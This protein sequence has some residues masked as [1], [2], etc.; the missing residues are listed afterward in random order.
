VYSIT[1][2]DDGSVAYSGRAFVKAVGEQRSRLTK[3]NLAE[4]E[5]AFEEAGFFSL[6]DRYS[7]GMLEGYT[8]V[9]SFTKGGRTKRV[10]YYVGAGGDPGPAAPGRIVPP[11][12]W[13]LAS[14]IDAIVGSA[15]WVGRPEEAEAAERERR[16][17][18]EAARTSDLL[19]QLKDPD[20]GVRERAA[21]ALE[22]IG[23]EGTKVLRLLANALRRDTNPS[24]RASAAIA[25]SSMGATAVGAVPDLVSALKDTDPGVRRSAA[26]ALGKIGPKARAAVPALR[27]ALADPA[28][29]TDAADA[30]TRIAADAGASPLPKRPE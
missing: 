10:E 8:V 28:I 6:G 13:R 5:K 1:V 26:F 15:R 17:Q 4:L 30:L 27:A 24:V 25:L 22:S 3:T 20:D 23:P 21:R 12:L 14:R 11:A 2:Y 7:Q 16:R 29:R 18:E 19:A 9:I